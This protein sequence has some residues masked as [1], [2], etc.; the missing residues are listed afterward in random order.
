MVPGLATLVAEV[1]RRDALEQL[2]IETKALKR[3]DALQK[4]LL[5]S[6]SHDLR[7]P[8]TAITTA[9]G[10]MSSKTLSDEARLELTSVAA[11]SETARLSRLVE[12]LLDLSRLQAGN[13]RPRREWCSID[14]IMREAIRS[15][16]EPSRRLRCPAS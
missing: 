13:L 16:A 6:I 11:T 8:L 7:T 2:V 4:A 14:E 5:R 9:V 10:G 15:V 3:S 12:N 1:R